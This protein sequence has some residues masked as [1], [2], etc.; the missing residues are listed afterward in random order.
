MESTYFKFN[1]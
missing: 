1:I